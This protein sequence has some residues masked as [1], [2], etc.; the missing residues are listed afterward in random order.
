MQC[1]NDVKQTKHTHQQPVPEI[2][3]NLEEINYQV[4]IQFWQ[5]I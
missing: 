1:S 5:I 4:M 3:K 2:H